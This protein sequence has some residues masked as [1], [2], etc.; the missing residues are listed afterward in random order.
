MMVSCRRHDQ[1]FI[2]KVIGGKASMDSGVL[3]ELFDALDN[4]GLRE[5][6]NYLRPGLH[7]GLVMAR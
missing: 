2:V 1:R 6:R 4:C 3:T 5:V 7:A